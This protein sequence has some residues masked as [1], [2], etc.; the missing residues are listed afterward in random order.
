MN[1]VVDNISNIIPI[2][3]NLKQQNLEDKA[4]HKFAQQFEALFLNKLLDSMQ[5]TMPDSGFDTDAASGQVKG[6]FTMF[7][8]QAVAKEGGVGLADEIYNS[9]SKDKNR[10]SIVN[11]EV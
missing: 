10:D 2:S 5:D 11:Q 4:K 7:M 8:S 1:T 3:D 9:M 6:L